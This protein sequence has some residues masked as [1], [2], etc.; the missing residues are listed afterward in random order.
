MLQSKTCA[1]LIPCYNEEKTIRNVVQQCRAVL[2]EADIIVCDNQSE[3]QTA[4]EA[5]SAGARVL[6][7]PLRGKG[8]AVRRLFREVDADCYVMIDGDETYD[9]SQLPKMLSIFQEQ[10]LDMLIGRRRP[11]EEQAYRKGHVLGNRF[12]N[13]LF[14]F[15]FGAVFH[16]IFSGF[17]IFSRRFVKSFPCFSTGFEIETELSVHALEM[18]VPVGEVDTD[19]FPRPLGSF[20]KLRTYRDGWRVLCTFSKLFKQIRPFKLFSALAL[21]LLSMSMALFIPVFLTYLKVGLVPRFPTLIVA[22]SLVILA[23]LFVFTGIILAEISRV[24]LENR[25]LIYLMES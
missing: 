16:D 13:W 17:R 14:R 12:F 10:H 6:F 1:V 19:Y 23:T 22:L 24:R 8:H 7:E 9:L 18:Q 4:A 11:V 20:S 21:L 2:P 15:L 5:T 25:F 3:D